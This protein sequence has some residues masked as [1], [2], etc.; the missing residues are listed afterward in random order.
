MFV[1]CISSRPI[2]GSARCFCAAHKD[3]CG[4]ATPSVCRVQH[5]ITFTFVRFV[6]F[7]ISEA[8]EIVV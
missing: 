8:K 5:F 6:V 2:L 7:I 1:W 4:S 3:L